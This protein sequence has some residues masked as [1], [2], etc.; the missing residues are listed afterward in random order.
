[1]RIFLDIGAH[2]GETLDVVLDARW[3]FDRIFSFEPA[4]SCWPAL[5]SRRDPRLTL[6]RFGLWTQDTSIRLHNPGDVGASVAEDKDDVESSALCDFRDAGEWF[7]QNVSSD[8]EVFAKINIEGAEYEVVER[9]AASGQLAK[10]DHLLLHLDVRKSPSRAHLEPLIRADLERAGVEYQTADQIQF[11]GVLRGT[12]NWL[13]WCAADPRW[14]DLR[15]KRLRSIESR[16]RVALYPL[17]V[18]VAGRRGEG[19][20]TRN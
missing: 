8:D 12:R 20:A 18:R 19:S 10:I 2:T 17:K 15:Y 16:A 5:E 7:E 11:G 4:P 9:L 6:C 14:R 1:M 3:K 13:L